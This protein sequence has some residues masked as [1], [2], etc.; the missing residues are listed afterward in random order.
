ARVYGFADRGNDDYWFATYGGVS[1]WSEGKWTHYPS[2][3]VLSLV[4]D[5]SNT[6]W[7]SNPNGLQTIDSR[8][9]IEPAHTPIEY[10]IFDLQVDNKGALWIATGGALYCHWNGAWTTYDARSGLPILQLRGILPTEDKVYIGSQGGGLAILNLQEAK[11]PPLISISNPVVENSDV[12]LRWRA[13]AYWGSSPPSEIETQFSVDRQEW[14]DWNKSQ[15]ILLHDLSSGDHTF[16]L[17]A[18]TPFGSFD[19]G[20]AS[21]GFVVLPPTFRRPEV[22]IPVGVLLAAT[23]YLTISAFTRKRRHARELREHRDRIASDL[24]DEVGSNLG[25]IAL[26]SQRLK[27]KKELPHEYQSELI[28]ISR[29]ALTTADTIRE[30]VWY[31]NPEHDSVENLIVKMREFANILFKEFDY[32]FIT[33]NI[34]GAMEMDLNAR[35]NMFL[36]FKETVHNIIRHAHATK[37]G[38]HI[39]QH[40]AFLHFQITDNG[41]GFDAQDSFNGHG[42]VNLRKRAAAIHGKLLIDS[43]RESGTLVRFSAHI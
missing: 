16:Q 11:R 40:E 28:T 23:T 25:S 29:T 42:L 41:H 32:S 31:I 38:I 9:S 24:H 5:S 37:V 17:R 27:K 14:S 33:E 43:S 13:Y 6:V 36:M 7:F 18:K 4:V 2:M 19:I 22:A 15:E 30:I 21:V 3:R 39:L 12:L 35:R 8:D 20:S 10:E 1:R 26:V 34:N